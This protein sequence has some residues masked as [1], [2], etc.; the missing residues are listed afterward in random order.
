MI[1]RFEPIWDIS[2]LRR[3]WFPIGDRR[4][5]RWG[6]Q[7]LMQYCRL[8]SRARLK[9]GTALTHLLRLKPF[10]K[11]SKLLTKVVPCMLDY[12]DCWIRFWTCICSLQWNTNG[13]YSDHFTCSTGIIP[14][15]L[16]LHCWRQTRLSC[17][18]SPIWTLNRRAQDP[19]QGWHRAHR[20]ANTARHSR[21]HLGH[22]AFKS[23]FAD[24]IALISYP[25]PVCNIS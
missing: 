22:L 19:A 3:G 14:G 9:L 24:D 16:S 6:G 7:T 12:P 8:I 21:G 23:K 10:V 20:C 11:G 5:L 15:W 18:P 4:L 25:Q 17:K 2:A 1:G 13:W